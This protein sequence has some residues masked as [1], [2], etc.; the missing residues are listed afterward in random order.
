M[1]GRIQGLL[2]FLRYSHLVMHAHSLLLD[3]WQVLQNI[4][5]SSDDLL[6]F[7]LSH[8]SIQQRFCISRD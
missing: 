1:D 6:S 7:K 8:D 4:Q 3:E 2:D 5:P